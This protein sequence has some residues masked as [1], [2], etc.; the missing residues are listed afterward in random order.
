MG[1]PLIID[2]KGN[3]LDD[4]PGIRSVIFFKGCPLRCSWCHNPESKRAGLEIS[5]DRELC[6]A[7]G[8]CARECP[9]GAIIP[10]TPEFI[11]RGRCNLCGRC[12][13]A[14]PSR[15]LTTVGRTMEITEIMQQ[16]LKDRPFFETSGGGVTLSG[17]EPTLHMDFA[18]ELLK[19]LK[20]AG[21]HTLVETCGLFDLDDF[22]RRVLPHTDLIFMDIKIFDQAAHKQHC[23]VGNELIL[24]NFKRLHMLT[25]TEGF[26]ILPRT[27]L[28]PG[29]SDTAENLTGIAGFLAA[30]HVRKTQLLS[31]NP[32][33]EDKTA[34]LGLDWP[35][36][37]NPQ[38]KKW[39]APQRMEDCR[40]FYRER[41]IEVL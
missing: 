9:A 13:E 30:N 27:P 7:C 39:T 11:D 33:W 12:I 14:C 15:A 16:V 24:D 41:G 38:L 23:G 34:K 5:F 31:Y 26:D 37:D 35:F 29:I 8:N 28:V 1:K 6:I 40:Q 36:A 25:Q 22:C 21:I 19:E 2:I 17:G 10:D 3:S 32:L 20:K 4:G 18:G